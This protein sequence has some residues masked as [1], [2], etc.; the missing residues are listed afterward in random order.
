DWLLTCCSSGPGQQGSLHRSDG[1]TEDEAEAEDAE[2]EE[3]EEEVV[4]QKAKPETKELDMVAWLALVKDHPTEE[5][6]A[7]KTGLSKGRVK[8][9]MKALVNLK[10]VSRAGYSLTK[11]GEDALRLKEH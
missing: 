1:R 6:L 11:M 9:A 10:L 2:L 8:F 7:E 5:A 4:M 3:A